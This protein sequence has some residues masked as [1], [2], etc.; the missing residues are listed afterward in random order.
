MII[1]YQSYI[2]V[3]IVSPFACVFNMFVDWCSHRFIMGIIIPTRD[4][5]TPCIKYIHEETKENFS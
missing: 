4:C 3:G 1:D 2:K 5:Q